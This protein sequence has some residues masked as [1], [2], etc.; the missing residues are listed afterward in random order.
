LC[1]ASHPH[2]SYIIIF[3]KLLFYIDIKLYAI[4]VWMKVGGNSITKVIEFYDPLPPS[5]MVEFPPTWREFYHPGRWKRVI[6]SWKVR[7]DS[8]MLICSFVLD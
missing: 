5:R 7:M 4:L 3:A 1:A 6:S 2:R 8:I